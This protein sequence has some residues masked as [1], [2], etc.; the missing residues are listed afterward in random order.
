MTLP[1][2]NMAAG[3]STKYLSWDIK[4]SGIQKSSIT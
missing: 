3:M 4:I 2:T 1:K